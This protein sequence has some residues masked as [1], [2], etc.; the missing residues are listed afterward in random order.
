[1]IQIIGD[2]D[3][4][5]FAKFDEELSILE[6]KHKSSRKVIIFI[7]LMSDGGDATS[8]LAFFDRIKLSPLYIH[9]TAYGEV[10]SAATLIFAAGDHRVMAPNSSLFFHEEQAGNLEGTSLSDA[11]KALN[12]HSEVDNQ[13]NELMASVSNAPA[14]HYDYLNINE[15]YLS[16]ADA[17]EIGL[18]D[19]VLKYKDKK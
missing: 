5:S 10:G 12:R 3:A 4:A 9:I 14:S 2:I 7:A 13:Y 6:L 17:K 15:S 16:P 18:C 1:M 19:A 8:G 11:K